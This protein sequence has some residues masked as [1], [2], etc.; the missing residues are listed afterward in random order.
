VPATKNIQLLFLMEAEAMTARIPNLKP[1]PNLNLRS[2]VPGLER[3]E[4]MR[5]MMKQKLLKSWSTR[6]MMR[7]HWN[8]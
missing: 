3:G 7:F 8:L 1:S 6:K 4:G 2:T 5:L